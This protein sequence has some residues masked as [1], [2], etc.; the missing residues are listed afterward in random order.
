M[1]N[2]SS[3][4]R[5]PVLILVLV[6]VGLII[7]WDMQRSVEAI[8]MAVAE[9]RDIH[10]GV[11]TNGKAEP[12]EYRDIRSEVD[13]QI[14]A[15]LVRDGDEVRQG[16]TLIEITQKQITSDIEHARADV[17]EAEEALRVLKQG[18]TNVDLRQLQIQIDAAQRELDVAAKTVA[19]N[20]RLVE[21]GAVSRMELQQ[22]RDR[23]A[24]AE[25][26]LKLLQQK[27]TSPFDPEAVAKA[28]VA[29]AAHRASLTLAL[30][31]QQSSSA[32]APLRGTVYSL[33]VRLGDFV[34]AGDMLLRVG[35]FRKIRVRVYVD[36][37]DLGRVSNGQAVTVSWDGLPGRQWRGEVNRLP[38]EIRELGTRKVGE[39]SCVLDNP[40]Q[41]LL[42]NMN[43][44]VEIVT[45]SKPGVVTIPR[46]ALFGTENNRQV[47][48]VHDG[49]LQAQT[50]KTGISNVNRV[51]VIQGLK[52][53][54]QVGLAS[55]KPLRE[56]MR[57]RN[58]S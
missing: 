20:E 27:K 48:V 23:L 16:Q 30:A 39:V 34:H 37:P 38:S 14:S 41:E 9:R 4:W 22:S 12:V 13:G 32:V 45:A 2:R 42:P 31:R 56:G 35:D 44:N 5:W 26:E 43:L 17:A 58:A 29:I 53:G 10:T 6:A 11:V 3:R 55:E 51:E 18:G 50:V 24:K 21:K 25:A 47:Y 8:P 7:R 52:E 28:E 33:S 57:V 46:E 54:D 36:E 19:D 1:A 15:V 49:K 40:S